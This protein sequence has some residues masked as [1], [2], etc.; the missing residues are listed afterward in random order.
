[1]L[2]LIDDQSPNQFITHK[3]KLNVRVRVLVCNVS[4]LFS[5]SHEAADISDY[6][7]TW[8]LFWDAPV[9]L[10]E[11]NGKSSLENPTMMVGFSK[12]NTEKVFFNINNKSI[13]SARRLRFW[14]GFLQLEKWIQDRRLWLDKKKGKNAKYQDRSKERPNRRRYTGLGSYGKTGRKHKPFERQTPKHKS[15]RSMPILLGW[16]LLRSMLHYYIWFFSMWPVGIPEEPWR[17]GPWDCLCVLN[18][19][20]THPA[21]SR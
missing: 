21:L 1:M 4:R 5:L 18:G 15:S 17:V 11:R 6:W 16:I 14:R 13:C 8:R 12:L 7:S 20:W 10:Q 19:S 3:H 2:T 9:L